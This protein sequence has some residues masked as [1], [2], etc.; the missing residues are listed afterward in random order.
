MV[1]EGF[2]DWICNR[3][4]EDYE[5]N[6]KRKEIDNKDFRIDKVKTLDINSEYDEFKKFE[7]SDSYKNV[8]RAT[9]LLS[10]KGSVTNEQL[11]SAMQRN[12]DLS[13]LEYGKVLEQLANSKNVGVRMGT[14]DKKIKLRLR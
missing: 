7:K 13:A 9:N 8:I 14:F 3:N 11:K 1:D 4:E 10:D 12:Y 6:M 2:V 5:Y